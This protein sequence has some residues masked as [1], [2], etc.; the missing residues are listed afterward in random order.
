VMASSEI[1]SKCFI[2]ARMELPC[3]TMRTRLL[4]EG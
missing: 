1:L 3:A 4:P 2:S